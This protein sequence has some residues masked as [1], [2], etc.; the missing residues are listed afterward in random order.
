M[1]EDRSYW[2]IKGPP[3]PERNAEDWQ[4]ARLS[5]NNIKGLILPLKWPIPV[6]WL[7]HDT[8]VAYAYDDREKTK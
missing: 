4:W 1:A 5:S 2:Q 6:K 8:A 7:A 3:R